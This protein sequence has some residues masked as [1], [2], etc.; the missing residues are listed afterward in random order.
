MIVISVWGGE[1]D[2]WYCGPVLCANYRPSTQAAS[3][4]F[5]SMP[6]VVHIACTVRDG[7]M[8]PQ[9]NTQTFNAWALET[10]ASHPKG[11]DP[12]RFRLK[13]PPPGYSCKLGRFSDHYPAAQADGRKG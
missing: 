10:L 9:V 4:Y 7:H 13:P 2:K 11:S 1:N 12:R 5:S 6:N 8:W 3:N